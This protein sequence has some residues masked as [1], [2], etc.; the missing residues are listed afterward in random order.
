MKVLIVGGVA[1][2]ASAATRLRRQREDAEI[3]LFER[4]AEVSFANCGLPYYLGNVI[5]ERD[6]LLVTTPEQLRRRFNLDVRTLSLVESI[7]RKQQTVTVRNVETQQVYQE[8]YDRL[9]LATGA[10]PVQPPIQGLDLKGVFRLRSMQDTD[11][12]FAALPYAN[13]AVVVGA[14]FIGLEMVENLRRRN[15]QVTL[16]ELSDQLLPPLDREMTPRLE[17]VLRREQ[18]DLRLGD[19]LESI[20]QTDQGLKIHLRSGHSGTTDLVLVGVG[21]RPE[22]SLAVQAGLAVGSRGGVQVD[23]QMRTTD[24]N[25]YA[26]GDLIEVTDFVTSKATQIPLAGPANRQGRLAADSIA[27]KSV[28]FRGTQGTAIVGLFDLT[29]AATGASEKTL[30]AQQIPYDKVYIHPNQHAGYYPGASQLTLKLLFAPQS[31]KILGAQAVGKEGVDKRIDVLAMALF[32][33]MTVFDLEEAELCYAPPFGS[34]KD[35]INMAGFVAA[36]KIR[37]EH[38]QVTVDALPWDH[39][40][41]DV[42]SPAEFARGHLPGAVNIPLDDLRARLGELPTSKPILAYC[43]VGMRGYL[44]TRILLQKGLKV[45]NLAGGYLTY[46]HFGCPQPVGCQESRSEAIHE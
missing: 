19:S 10:A 37:G 30:K 1:G 17:D 12:I 20:E 28:S 23:D 44:A 4:G 21:V 18:V 5:P 32:A 43:Q 34:A 38:P 15:L 2:G 36:N 27:G 33:G 8:S 11:Q 41:L 40:L 45:T 31:G 26:V 29:A 46:Q 14:G 7:D 9:I 22:N 6:Q 25:I 39:F 13:S 24:P 16:V 3:I 35:P 42:R